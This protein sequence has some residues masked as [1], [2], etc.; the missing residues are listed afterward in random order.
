MRYLWAVV[1]VDRDSGSWPVATFLDLPA[2]FRAWEIRR[3]FL[4]KEVHRDLRL[5][6]RFFVDEIDRSGRVIFGSVCC[7]LGSG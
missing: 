2:R 5:C 1:L 6:L 7:V 3:S 4:P